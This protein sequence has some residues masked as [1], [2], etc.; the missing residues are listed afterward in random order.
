[1]YKK[2]IALVLL[3]ALGFYA[4]AGGSQ[5]KKKAADTK[6]VN[7]EITISCYDAGVAHKFLE[8]TARLF[9]QKYPGTKVTVESFSALPEIKTMEQGA[10]V[11]T[12]VQNTDDPQGRSAYIN[13]V[14]TSLMSGGG[15]DIYWAGVLPVYV[16]ADNGQFENLEALMQNDPDFNRS[17]YREN[18]LSAAHYHGGLYF[19]PTQYQFSYYTYDG[20]LLSGEAVKSFGIQSALSAGDLLASGGKFFDGTAKLFNTYDF[21]QGGAG[22]MFNRLLTESY[23]SFVDLEGKKASFNDGRFAALLER[24]RGYAD[25]G[26][27]PRGTSGQKDAEQIMRMAQ[28]LQSERFFFKE[29]N[30]FS[31]IQE[32]SRGQGPRLMLQSGG[33]AAG[34]EDDDE[35]A[36][37]AANNDGSVPFSFADGYAIN[38]ASKNKACAWNFIKFLLDQEAQLSTAL[39][40]QFLPL[41]NA[42]RAEKAR[43][44]LS[45]AFI[46]RAQALDTVQ[47]TILKRYT[48]AVERLSDRINTYTMQDTVLNDMISAEASAFFRGQKSA[49]EAARVLQNK[50]QLYLNE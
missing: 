4:F 19:M 14:N 37:I 10:M 8:N 36:G 7:T 50:A 39:S 15:A 41:N 26:L 31:L 6:A 22:G 24:L 5:E 27:I 18:I 35:I 49:G 30:N 11:M 46:G 3:A 21:V 25:K 33:S 17:L 9:E 44:L 34:I 45:G 48:D 42:A 47:E 38:A 29:K 12:R 13:R 1:M 20:I 23:S 43:L 28:D 32:F 40:P 16:Y 2:K